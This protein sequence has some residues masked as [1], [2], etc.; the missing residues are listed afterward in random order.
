MSLKKLALLVAAILL[1]VISLGLTV[2]FAASG[3]VLVNWHY[4][5]RY[6]AIC[7]PPFVILNP[8]RNRDAERVADEFLSQ[9]K[10]GNIHVLD[11]VVSD[12]DRLEHFKLSETQAKMRRWYAGDRSETDQEINIVYW[13][14]RKYD[15]GCGTVQATL[16]LT[17][18]DDRW[19]VTNYSAI[20]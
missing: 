6:G 20:Y 3:P 1:L 4:G 2:W 17:R 12:S 9:L 14:E 5:V 16:G 7:D 15:G 13:I 8:L 18:T 19:T 11:S 10:D